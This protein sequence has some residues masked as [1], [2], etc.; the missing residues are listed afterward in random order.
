M[1]R[2]RSEDKRDAIVAAAI[3]VIAAQGLSAPTATIAKA[4]GV[5]TGSLFLYFQT[6]ADLLN[7]VY[8]A[9]KSEMAVAVLDG[10]HARDDVREQLF[11]AW[12][13]WLQWATSFPKKRR[14]LAHLG[15]SD[16][17]TPQSRQ[18]GHQ[19]MAGAAEILERSRSG[20][21]MRDAPLG[22]VAALMNALAEATIDFII[23]DPAHADRHRIAGFDA[24]WRMFT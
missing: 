7:A 23:S 9:L 20:G 3:E 22:F 24:M 2:P 15:V 8:V 21:P 16:E 19:A 4:A 18:T 14:A 6:K 13:N 17:V 5:A 1:A 12:S 11:L 10:V